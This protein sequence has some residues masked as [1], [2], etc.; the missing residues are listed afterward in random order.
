MESTQL[1][2]GVFLGITI[3]VGAFFARFLTFGGSIATFFLASI[4]FAAGSWKWTLP[5]FVFFV[6]SSSLSKLG[7]PK[8]KQFESVFEKSGIRDYGQVL[9]NGGIGGLLALAQVALP[10]QDFYPAYLGSIAAVTAD[11]WGTELGLITRGRTYSI[12]SFKQVPQGTNGGVSLTGFAGG[13]IG[14]LT[15]ACSS[16][17]WIWDER[18]A[19][20]IVAAGLSGSL[21]DSAL[22]ATM[23]A[24]YQ[25]ESCGIT[26]ERRIHCSVPAKLVRGKQWITNDVVN[27]ACAFS[28][29]SLLLI[30]RHLS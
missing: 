11:T 9:A 5:I 29:A 25:C 4:I 15:I 16:A 30:F 10:S 19:V 12:I 21:I 20:G 14:A 17:P 27:W 22:G 8:K 1:V 26:T 23:Q 6:L 18:Q 13:A 7:Q 3:A 24:Q 28:G 2:T